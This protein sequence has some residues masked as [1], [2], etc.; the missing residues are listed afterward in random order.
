MKQFFILLCIMLMTFMYTNGQGKKKVCSYCNGT[1]WKECDKCRGKG[2]LVFSYGPDCTTLNES[3]HNMACPQCYRS[4]KIP[5]PLKDKYPQLHPSHHTNANIQNLNNSSI[6]DN[7]EEIRRCEMA[8]EELQN[9]KSHCPYCNG[10]QKI[11]VNCNTCNGSGIVQMGYYTPQFFRCNYCN[12]TGRR[13]NSCVECQKTD[14]SISMSRSMLKSFKETHGMKKEAAKVY[15][16]QNR[17]MAE[18]DLEYQ[19]ATDAIAEP[20]LK[21]TRKSNSSHSSTSSPQKCSICNGTGV[22][23]H[24]WEDAASNVG[25]NL[26]WCY[27]NSSGKKCPYCKKYTWHQH[28]KCPKCNSSSY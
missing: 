22:D 17:R 25:R 23:P 20:Y 1:G 3:E 7:S 27:T 13:Y 2:Y 4:R 16:E 24:P 6:I 15:H 12:G 9:R 11:P 5:C 21:S 14:V 28:H 18:M 19:R 10:T 8:I 26:P